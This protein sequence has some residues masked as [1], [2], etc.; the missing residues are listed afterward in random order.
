[1]PTDWWAGLGYNLKKDH[2]VVFDEATGKMTI[3]R[4]YIYYKI[5]QM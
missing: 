2:P 5:I 3:I 1:M 4:I